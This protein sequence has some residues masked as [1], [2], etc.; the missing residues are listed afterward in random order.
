MIVP[1]GRPDITDCSLFQ[2]LVLPLELEIAVHQAVEERGDDD[3]IV[4]KLGPVLDHAVA[5]EDSPS[6]RSSGSIQGGPENPCCL[7]ALRVT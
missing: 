6:P 7:H 2:A 5:C 3:H 1:D 4:E